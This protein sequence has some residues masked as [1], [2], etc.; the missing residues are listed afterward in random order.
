MK[1]KFEELHTFEE[2]NPLPKSFEEIIPELR[3]WGSHSITMDLFHGIE[4]IQRPFVKLCLVH[5]I[6]GKTKALLLAF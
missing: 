2:T 5:Q 1:D 6:F 4:Q 3:H